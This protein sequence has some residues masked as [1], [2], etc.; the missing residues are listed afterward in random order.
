PWEFRILR[1]EPEPWRPEDTL[2]IGKGFALL[3]STALYTR[4]NFLALADKL[5]AQPEKLRALMPPRYPA[6]A[7]T[8]SRAIWQQA[9]AAWQFVSGALAASD[10]QAAGHGSNS[11]AVA[12]ERAVNGGAILCNDPHLRMTLPSTWYLMH[13]KAEANGADPEGY[14]VW[15]ASIPGIPCIHLGHNRW[16]AWGVTAAVCD[17][18]EIYRE[19]L[20]RLEP[21]RYLADNRWE[22]FETRREQVAIRGKAA[23][24]II[25]RRSRHGPVLSDFSASADANEILSLRWTAHEPSEELRSVYG[26]NRAHDWREFVDALRFHSAPSLNFLYADRAGNIGYSLA[27][28][29][30]RRTRVPALAPLNGWE[31]ENEWPDYLAFEALPR[32]Y[33][34]PRRSLATANNRVADD[35]YPFYLSHFYEPPQRIRRIEQLLAAREKFTADDLSAF[36]LDAVSLHGRELRDKLRDDIAAVGAGEPAL[37]TMVARLLAWDGDCAEHSVE[38]AIFHHFHHRLLVKLLVPD[39]GER[40]FSAAVEILNQCIVATDEILADPHS[41]WFAARPRAGLVEG[42]LR[43]AHKELAAAFG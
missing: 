17:D 43:Q 3:L 22:K 12:P 33:N 28:K 29:I 1:H 4:L 26:V 27:G 40:L 9:G 19:K 13:L 11:W 10:W 31:P 42:A 30:P 23:R 41:P 14:E 38:A 8:I 32:I 36:Q 21:D 6:D 7:P 34:P 35:S 24:Q 5:S 39:L 20:H 37:S 18:V 15:G 25:L 2:T 16:I